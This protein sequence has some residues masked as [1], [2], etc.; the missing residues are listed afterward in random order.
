M[1]SDPQLILIV[2]IILVIMYYTRNCGC[3]SNASASAVKSEPFGF[4]DFND[5]SSPQE[6]DWKRTRYNS[7]PLWNEINGKILTIVGGDS[8]NNFDVGQKFR[9]HARERSIYGNFSNGDLPNGSRSNMP[10]FYVETSVDGKAWDLHPEYSA[11]GDS[12]SFEGYNVVNM[13]TPGGNLKFV[14]YP[15]GRIWVGNEKGEGDLRTIE[16]TDLKIPFLKE[17][18]PE[19][20]ANQTTAA[21]TTASQ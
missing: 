14:R 5:Y 7:D 1:N 18:E 10:F 6:M 12:I 2:I 20:G 21:L 15:N 8:L 4:R 11:A 17:D 9:L 13:Y 16:L 3:G 19:E